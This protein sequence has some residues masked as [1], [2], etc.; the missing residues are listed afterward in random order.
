MTIEVR[1]AF[2][3]RWVDMDFNQHMRNAAFLGC[4]EETRMRYM[5]AHGFP[6]TELARLQIGPVVLEDRIVYKRELR[7][8]EAFTVDLALAAMSDDGRKM[9]M[10][11]RFVTDADGALCATVESV[12]L[13]FDIAARKPTLPPP[14]LLQSMLSLPR[15]EDFERW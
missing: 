11:S 3:A 14:A 15:T 8:L 9:K 4:A 5:S 10:R 1:E 12:G 2:V 13:W 6:V 7:L